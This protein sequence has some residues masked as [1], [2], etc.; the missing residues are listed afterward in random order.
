MPLSSSRRAR[1]VNAASKDKEGIGLKQLFAKATPR[2][3]GRAFA[4]IQFCSPASPSL[5]TLKEEWG[6]LNNG[7]GLLRW[8]VAFAISCALSKK[9][10]FK[11]SDNS[12]FTGGGKNQTYFW[13]GSAGV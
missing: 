7:R 2:W 3:G 11:K 8:G 12:C 4:L 5:Y 1:G 10:E 6:R 9:E 13:L